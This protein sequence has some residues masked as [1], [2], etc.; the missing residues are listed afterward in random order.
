V[1]STADLLAS[2]A[3]GMLANALTVDVEDWHQLVEWKLTGTKPAC[4][5]LV[6]R[7]TLD[8]MELLS[9]HDV[10]ATFFVLAPVASAFPHLIR[11]IRAAGHEVASHGWSH[12]LV[13]RQT[14]EEFARETRQ[15]KA[16]LEDLLG[17]AIE[18]YRAAEFS[19]TRQSRWA[20]DVLAELGFRYDSSIFPIRGRRY[21][22]PD[23]PLGPH[24]VQTSSGA[25]L[26]E[27]PLTALPWGG[28]RWPVGGGGYFRLLPYRVT[29]AAI[30]R[31][32]A[33]GRPAVLFH[34]YEF[35]REPLRLAAVSWP[36]YLASARYTMFHNVNRH[37]NRRRLHR[38]LQDV[39]C[40]PVA[41]TLHDGS[42]DAQVL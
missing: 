32:N 16:L 14:R 9:R 31:V 1:P 3:R 34:P 33:A 11:A 10:R 29:R 21:G 30:D 4:S 41:D 38:L 28:R 40:A 6:E 8:V 37:A 13:Y 26:T 24:R 17:T 15:A 22:I 42:P 23:A 2:H 20:L 35:S 19:I 36:R 7:H 27:V 5:P 12:R 25:W 18:G 39:R